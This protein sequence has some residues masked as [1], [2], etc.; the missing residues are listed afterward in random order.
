M[1]N[2]I[3]YAILQLRVE[4]K[5]ILTNSN[6]E[7]N[8][9]NQELIDRVL[10]IKD[11]HTEPLYWN[12][13]DT[14]KRV[15]TDSNGRLYGVVG[16]NDQAVGHGDLC[17]RV[18]EW[19]PEGK[20]VSCVT[21]GQNHTKAIINIE[22][23]KTF[24][25]GGQEIKT[26]VGL[27]NSLDGI[28]KQILWVTP[29]RTSCTNQFVLNKKSAYISLEHKHT[30]T[31]VQKFNQELRLVEEVYNILKGQLF[32]A[33]KLINNPCTTAKGIEFI[34]NLV[35]GKIIPEKI[36]KVAK[37]LYEHPI[38]QEDEGR[39]FWTLFNSITDPLNR[40]LEEKKKTQSFLNIERVGE[41]FTE[42]ASELVVG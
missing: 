23:P 18:Q 10:S 26:Y 37:E 40:E 5:P 28:W 9:N 7:G 15:I 27:A 8:M 22:L 32:L 3:K 14:R 12:G 30:R 11:V 39:N 35:K 25:V 16:R 24:D 2:V 36:G 4:G 29:M 31:G 1:T 34:S 41:V 13:K 33:E 19:L 38:R 21:G 17:A 42:V 6:K 20:V